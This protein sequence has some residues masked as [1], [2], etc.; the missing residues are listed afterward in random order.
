[1]GG[2]LSQLPGQRGATMAALACLSSSSS[3]ANV[4]GSV[5]FGFSCIS[6]FVGTHYPV[7]HSLTYLD[8]NYKTKALKQQPSEV[9]GTHQKCPAFKKCPKFAAKTSSVVLNI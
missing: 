5:W 7:A 8:P 1:M 2:G 3:S 4:S 9:V 6:T